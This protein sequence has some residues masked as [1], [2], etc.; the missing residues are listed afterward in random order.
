MGIRVCAAQYAIVHESFGIVAGTQSISNH[1]INLGFDEELLQYSDGNAN[2]AADIRSSS[3]SSGS[4]ITW[5]SILASGEANLWF[6]SSGDRGFSIH[7]I[8]A[9]SF[10]SL[11]LY[12]AYRKESASS[13][14]DFQVY[15]SI[16][17]DQ[18]WDSL[19]GIELPAD[20]LSTGWYYIGPINL[21]SATQSNQLSLRW[22]KTQGSMRLDDISLTGRINEPYVAIH[23][24]PETIVGYAGYQASSWQRIDLTF[25]GIPEGDSVS[26]LTHFP[27][28]ISR[29]TLNLRDTLFLFSDSVVDSKFIWYRIASD[30]SRANY[31][32][33]LFLIYDSIPLYSIP[34]EGLLLHAGESTISWDC[35]QDSFVHTSNS[36]FI[37]T[38]KQGNNKGS[39]QFL[40]SSSSSSGYSGASGNQNA[41]LSAHT[42][43]LDTATSSYIAWYIKPNEGKELLLAGISFGARAT[44]TGPKSWALRSSKD[45]FQHNLYS[46]TLTNNSTWQW[47]KADS[48][49]I[50]SN[51]S[52]IF[53]LYVFD[54]TGSAST[55]IANFRMDDLSLQLTSWNKIAD[56]PFR[57]SKSGDIL[58]SSMWSYAYYDTLYTEA[59]Q[60]PSSDSE[61]EIRAQD[62]CW[63]STNCTLNSLEL[64][65]YL[66]MESHSLSITGRLLGNGSLI[67]NASSILSI[68]GTDSSA[69]HFSSG[70][71]LSVL[72]LENGNPQVTLLDTLTITRLLYP[73]AGTLYSQGMLVLS[74]QHGAYAQIDPAA[75]GAIQGALCMQTLIPGNNAGWRGFMSPLDTVT[76]GQLGTQLEIHEQN[77]ASSGDNRNCYTWTES[78]ASWNSVDRTNF[79]LHDSAVNLFI[80]NSDS[81]PIRLCGLYDT[82]D[83]NLGALSFT[84]SNSQTEGWHFIG[85][86]FPSPLRWSAVSQPNGMNGNMAIWSV[87]DGNYRTWNG[88][89]GSAGDLIPPFQGF[90]VKVNQSLSQDFILKNADRDTG[91]VN[92]FGKKGNSDFISIEVKS[93]DTGY[94]D[95]LYVL[96]HDS[97]DQVVCQKLIGSQNAPQ[98]WTTNQQGDSLSLAAIENSAVVPVSWYCP[99]KGSYEFLVQTAISGDALW[100]L[101]DN[102]AEKEF[103]VPPSGSIIVSSEAGFYPNRFV[104][105][106]KLIETSIPNPEKA[107]QVSYRAPYLFIEDSAIRAIQF[108]SMDGRKVGNAICSIAKP[109]YFGP[110]TYSSGLYILEITTDYSLR[111]QIIYIP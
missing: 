16:D 15:Y 44:S 39:T 82:S 71:C 9:A 37:G 35:E 92:H 42:G 93:P 47:V 83:R 69:L 20:S 103:A 72:R 5:D 38:P 30:T 8:R 41:A 14:A 2:D 91:S 56:A 86:P 51:D 46:G 73:G 28:D 45:S 19:T 10:D 12:F 31:A 75:K 48:L 74:A 62:S 60:L 68:E 27:F 90:W 79:P 33:S 65:G 110:I 4:Y 7:G 49:G 57:S 53:R 32:D 97:A 111:R 18:S 80:F 23:S 21:P 95:A 77:S 98:I 29:D 34:I 106:K 59:N 24:L 109:S 3:N 63:L 84:S 102:Q 43:S 87:E 22:I 104:L 13:N 67:S 1:A 50:R 58:D 6:S 25:L 54:G 89:I 105:K 11:N 96:L 17:N 70:S 85:N 81:T 66:N 107:Y 64:K 26:V 101:S 100:V 108:Y 78:N 36:L 94:R 61:I 99:K 88:S 76:L 55:N 52:L 40:S